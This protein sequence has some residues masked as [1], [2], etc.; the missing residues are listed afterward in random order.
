MGALEQERFYSEEEF[1]NLVLSSDTKYEYFDGRIFAMAG[2]TLNHSLIIE[3]LSAVLKTKLRGK[4]CRSLGSN[5]HIKIVSKNVRVIPDNAIFC[6]SAQFEG[7]KRRALLNPIVV[8]EVL[9]S[10]TETYDRREKFDLYKEISSLRDYVL[11]SQD[12]VR[13]EHFSR[14]DDGWLLRTLTLPHQIVKLESVEL[15]FSVESLYD[16]LDIPVQLTL[17]S[18]AQGE[19]D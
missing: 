5:L 1:W 18:T 3:N 19:D 15:E 13:V 8:F 2:G 9:S 12:I 11:V 6:E 10:Q 7:E 4:K 16:E 17:L 14:R